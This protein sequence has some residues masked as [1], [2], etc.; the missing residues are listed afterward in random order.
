MNMAL[1][2]AVAS[3]LPLLVVSTL[4]LRNSSLTASCRSPCQHPTPFSN[5]AWVGT[6]PTDVHFHDPCQHSHPSG[7]TVPSRR[8]M[9]CQGDDDL[10][11]VS[12][13]RPPPNR[14]VRTTWHD[15]AGRMLSG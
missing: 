2:P 7:L 13:M 5:P 10:L 14:T 8:H 15:W 11:V 9:N 3:T 6:W 1:S 4:I 12:P